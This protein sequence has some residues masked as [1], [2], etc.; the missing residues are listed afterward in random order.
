[1]TPFGPSWKR[2]DVS[3]V[4]LAVTVVQPDGGLA[5]KDD[6]EFLACVVE[7]VDELGSTRLEFPNRAAERT[8]FCSNQ[9]S[10]THPA[11]V[12]NFR[13]ETFR[14]VWQSAVKLLLLHGLLARPR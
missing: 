7:V 1:M 13:P 3:L 11:P 14:V 4:E 5:T 9:G 6:D 8:A 12:G 2:H 10:R